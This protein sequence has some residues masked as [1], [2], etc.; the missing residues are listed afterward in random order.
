MPVISVAPNASAWASASRMLDASIT[1]TPTKLT[2]KLERPPPVVADLAEERRVVVDPRGRPRVAGLAARA[3]VA[4]A[5]L[6][7]L[8]VRVALGVLV[9]RV[10]FGRPT[11]VVAPGARPRLRRGVGVVLAPSVDALLPA[12]CASVLVDVRPRRGTPWRSTTRYT[13]DSEIP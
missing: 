9:A 7:A 3:E 2:R 11:P 12:V 6:L 4:D 10:P 13:E 1:R 5:P 8:G